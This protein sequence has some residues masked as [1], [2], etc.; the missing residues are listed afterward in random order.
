MNQHGILRLEYYYFNIDKCFIHFN[1]DVP[2]D[3]ELIKKI[4]C[5]FIGVSKDVSILSDVTYC[6]KVDDW[7]KGFGDGQAD[8]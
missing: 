6:K 5:D 2:R 1:S 3:S 8:K 4:I 7:V